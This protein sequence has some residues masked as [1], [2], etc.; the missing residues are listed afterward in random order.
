MSRFGIKQLYVNSF[1]IILETQVWRFAVALQNLSKFCYTST[2]GGEV[3][4]WDSKLPTQHPDVISS[5]SSTTVPSSR[6]ATSGISMRT[7]SD[8]AVCGSDCRFLAQEPRLRPSE[9]EFTP[10]KITKR[11]KT[12]TNQNV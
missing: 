5:M 10:E 12:S 3:F 4:Q 11:L 6:R 8:S 2:T 9:E 7:L 1:F